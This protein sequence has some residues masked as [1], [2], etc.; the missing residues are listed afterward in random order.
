VL[1]ASIAVS[2]LSVPSCVAETNRTQLVLFDMQIGIFDPIWRRV[3][4]R[5]AVAAS[6]CGACA[7]AG[8]DGAEGL[9]AVLTQSHLALVM[10]FAPG[11]TLLRYVSKRYKGE[12]SLVMPEDEARYYFHVR[13]CRK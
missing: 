6:T 2:K 10:E 8:A 9:Q 13:P 1:H 3:S 4:Q 11:G 12:G 7:G 5:P